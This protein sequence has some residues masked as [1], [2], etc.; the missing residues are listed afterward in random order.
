MKTHVAEK[1]GSLATSKSTSCVSHTFISLDKENATHKIDDDAEKVHGS[2]VLGRKP[3]PGPSCQALRHAVSSL[4]R[5]DDFHKET[6]GSG[7]FSEV[8][9]VTH[10]TTGQI[11]VLKMNMS[12]SNRP[13]MLREVQLMNRLAHFNILKFMGVC[14]HEGQLHALTEFINGGSLEEL[15]AEDV[16]LPWS[17]RIKLASDISRGIKYLHGKGVFHRDLTSKNVLIRKEDKTKYTAIVGDFGLA[18]KIPDP[19]DSDQHLATVG[20]PYWMAPECLIGERYNE[21]A[22]VFSYGIILCE[23]IS[24]Q[25]ADPDILPRTEK[26]GLDYV[27]FSEMVSD[28]PLNFLHLAFNCCQFDPKKRPSFPEIVNSVEE[29]MCRSQMAIVLADITKLNIQA[30]DVLSKTLLENIL[31]GKGHKRNRSDDSRCVSMEREFTPPLIEKRIGTDVEP[32]TALT[33]PPETHTILP[34]TPQVVGKVWSKDDVF[35]SP[36]TCNPF[37]SRFKD[38]AKIIAKDSWVS[39]FDLPSPIF[40]LTPP[41]TPVTPE[42]ALW[43]RPLRGRPRKCNSMPGSPTASRREHDQL[44]LEPFNSEFNSPLQRMG[45]AFSV[46]SS[47]KKLEDEIDDTFDNRSDGGSSNDSAVDLHMRDL[48]ASRCFRHGGRKYSVEATMMTSAWDFKPPSR[49]E[50]IARC[51]EARLTMDNIPHPRKLFSER[52]GVTDEDAMPPSYSSSESCMSL[53]ESAFLSPTS[54]LSSYSE[55]EEMWHSRTQMEFYEYKL[56]S[57]ERFQELVKR[58][59]AKQARVEE[60]SKSAMECPALAAGVDLTIPRMGLHVLS[61]KGDGTDVDEH[62]FQEIRKKFEIKQDHIGE[63][64]KMNKGFGPKK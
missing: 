42:E 43:L 7:F 58:W 9:K 29:I 41:C 23:I 30:D 21:K 14:V 3:L 27:A 55:T 40:P 61:E 48:Y 57:R 56:R 10:K 16:E 24:R 37:T 46:I 15:L 4:Y 8:Y 1:N 32:T 18:A 26:F 25:G 12:H 36:A 45:R 54:S 50:L 38:G 6:L 11:M 44:P 17:L 34:V 47:I 49:T 33:P 64:S 39:V 35:Y 13:N 28:C 63:E 20:S 60:S 5:L 53:D 2:P 19:L 59:E 62:R 51:M 52:H 31:D 22:D